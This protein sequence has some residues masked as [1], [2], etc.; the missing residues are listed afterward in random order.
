MIYLSSLLVKLMWLRKKA[1][2]LALSRPLRCVSY[3]KG[4]W[5]KGSILVDDFWN[6][7]C[8]SLNQNS[9][10]KSSRFQVFQG[11]SDDCLHKITH[12]H[13]QQKLKGWSCGMCDRGFLQKP[14]PHYGIWSDQGRTGSKSNL[15]K[16]KRAPGC[17]GYIPDYTA[18]LYGEYNIQLLRIPIKQPGFNGKYSAES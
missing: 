18:Q 13:H 4:L 11:V 9:C 14:P 6:H 3:M 1:S 8:F 5:R 12:K 7:R 10:S 16:E 15:I 2:S 17:L